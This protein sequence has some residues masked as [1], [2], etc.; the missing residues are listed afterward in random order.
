[1]ADLIAFL[2]FPAGVGVGVLASWALT[3]IAAANTNEMHRDD[4]IS[5][6]VTKFMASSFRALAQ[7][8]SFSNLGDGT[9]NR[10]LHGSEKIPLLAGPPRQQP[11][12]QVRQ[13]NAS[14]LHPSH[15]GLCQ[16]DSVSG[17]A[18]PFSVLVRGVFH[19][20][21]L[22]LYSDRSLEV[23]VAPMHLNRKPRITRIQTDQ[24]RYLL[25]RAIRI[26]CR[27][28]AARAGGSVVRD[29]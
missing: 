18:G 21:A 12:E 10:G 16:R 13:I 29:P 23:R 24:K 4:A 6:V 2:Y 11:I 25:I 28:V 14:F 7:K 17:F 8:A 15:V 5:R 19:S 9:G 27:A 22:S 1:M 3:L 26:T 20:S